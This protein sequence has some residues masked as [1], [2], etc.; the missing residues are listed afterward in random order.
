MILSE[1]LSLI[2]QTLGHTP[3]YPETDLLAVDREAW[4]I[5]IGGRYHVGKGSFELSLTE[6]LNT[7]G[8]PDFIVNLT[9]KMA[10]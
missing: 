4:L 9:Y 1:K 8:A 5:A 6:D 7:S 2:V 10:L 3:I